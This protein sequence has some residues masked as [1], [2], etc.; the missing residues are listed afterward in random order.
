MYKRQLV[1]KRG[2]VWSDA[3]CRKWALQ[4]FGAR[5]L[6]LKEHAAADEKLATQLRKVKLADVE[7]AIESRVTWER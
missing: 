3:R 7:A 2:A 1:T 5:A 6:R 4:A